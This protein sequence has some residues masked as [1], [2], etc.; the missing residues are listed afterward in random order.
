MIKVCVPATSANCC[1]GFDTMG[2]ALDWFSTF[3]FMPS[4]TLE[5][6]GCPEEFC[7]ENNLVVRSFK[8]ACMY[9]KKEMPAFKLNI[10]TDIPFSRGLGS[11]STCVVAGILAADAWFDA[12]LNKMELLK[13]ATIMEGHPDNV[14]PA[15]FGQACTSFLDED[16]QARLMMIPCQDFKGLALIPDDPIETSEA[17]KVLPQTLAYKDAVKQVAY[18][19][20]FAQSLT[21]GNELI[22]NK[23]CHDFLHE[24]YRSKLIKEYDE[25]KTYCESIDLAMWI[26][27]SGSTM[28]AISLEDEKLELLNNMVSKF[29]NIT[30]RKVS[31]SKKGAYVEYE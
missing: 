30:C 29:T 14:A 22:L 8:E 13:I 5:I 11:S 24:P 3:T 25:I 4:E 2:M 17:R 26:S 7:D 12:N 1:V 9:M 18:A 10:E 21:C 27:G 15:L 20:S 6:T 23:S 19:L 16:G 28:L 31:I